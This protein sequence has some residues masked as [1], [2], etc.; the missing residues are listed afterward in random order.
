[1]SQADAAGPEL[2][3]GYKLSW[4]QQPTAASLAFLGP[5][6][7]PKEAGARAN[8]NGDGA[9]SCPPYAPAAG[10]AGA[11][12]PRQ[13]QFMMWKVGGQPRL[14]SD[15][16]Y[17]K[18][19]R[20]GC[21]CLAP[22]HLGPFPRAAGLAQPVKE[23]T[24]C[25]A[26]CMWNT[27]RP[28]DAC[29]RRLRLWLECTAASCWRRA[30]PRLRCTLSLSSVIRPPKRLKPSATDRQQGRGCLE[31]LAPATA[32]AGSFPAGTQG[33]ARPASQKTSCP[34]GSRRGS[35]LASHGTWLGAAARRSAG[36]G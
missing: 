1:M 11:Q 13:L 23:G 21:C 20:W 10:G 8:V 34:L 36:C 28:W 18:I 26:C 32:T 5:F 2:P 25:C 24:W 31:D 17:R 33:C 35:G 27:Q 7:W 3:P 12:Q 30:S 22:A 4:P 14:G 16:Q 9:G 6:T 19:R 29:I 15:G